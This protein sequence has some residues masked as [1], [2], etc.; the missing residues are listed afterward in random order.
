MSNSIQPVNPDRE[1]EKTEADSHMHQY[2]AD[3]LNR[4][5]DENKPGNY[6]HDDEFE[7]K[8]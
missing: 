5:K 8:A 4:F 6:E 3:Q 7:A 2:I 1:K